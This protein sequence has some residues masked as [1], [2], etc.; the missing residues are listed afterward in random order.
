[1]IYSRC[2]RNRVPYTLAQPEVSA[3]RSASAGT[4]G[5]LASSSQTSAIAA[6][7]GVRDSLVGHA[8]QQSFLDDASSCRRRKDSFVTTAAHP[9]PSHLELPR[10]RGG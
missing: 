8:A 6:M 3:K 7:T 5:H 4:L 10:F 1:M 9:G 2:L